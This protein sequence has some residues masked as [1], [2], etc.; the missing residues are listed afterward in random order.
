MP[1]L[2]AERVEVANAARQTLALEN[3][4]STIQARSF[5]RSLQTTWQV[6]VIQWTEPES[7]SQLA[8]SRRLVHA[9]GIYEDIEGTASPGAIECYRRAAE[10]LEWLSRANDPIPV[11][12]PIQL[13]AAA[14]FQLG[15][16]PAMA[17]GLLSQLTQD[18]RGSRLYASFLRADFEQTLRHATAFWRKHP[19]LTARGASQRILNGEDE[20]SFSWYLV[21]ELVRCVGLLADSLRRGNDERLDRAL[22][23]LESLDR[24]ATRTLPE[25]VSLFITL[26]HRVAVRFGKDSIYRVTNRLAA[27][28]DDFSAKLNLFAR[29]QFSI[30]RGILWVSQ[31]RGLDRLLEHSSFALCTPTGSGKTLVA[32]LALVKELLLPEEDG[33]SPLGLYLVPSRALAG[34]VEAKLTAELGQDFVITGLYGGADWGITDYWLNADRPTVLIATVEKA[35]ALMRYLGPL[36]LSRLRLLIIDEAHQVVS[37]GSANAKVEFAEHSSRSLRLE[38][39]VSR[40]LNQKPEIVRI[41]LTAVAGGAALPVARWVEGDRAAEPVGIRYRSTRQVIGVLETAPERRSR[42]LLEMMNDRPLYVRG[43]D[44]PVFLRIQTPVMPQL[45][46]AMRNSIYRFNELS[47]LWTALHLQEGGRRILISVM[48]E[49]EQTM[50]WYAEA[51]ALEDWAEVGT[52][53]PPEEATERARFDETRA[54]CID[55]CGE[56][57]YEL[58]LLDRGI[59]TNHG[60]MPQ[61]LRRLMTDLI[62]RKICPVTVATAT[63]TE[64]VNLPFDLIFVTS[65]KRRFY[66]QSLRQIVDAP[67]STAEFRNLAGRAGRPGAGTGIEGMTLVALPQSPSSTAAT[68]RRTQLRQ[69]RGLREDYESLLDRLAADAR[70]LDAAVSPLALLLRSIAE[71]ARRLLG[72]GEEA[73]LDWIETVLPEDVSGNVGLAHVSGQARLADSIDELDGFLLAALEELARTEDEDI[74]GADAEAFLA[75]LWTST[76]ANSAAVQEAWLERAFIARG[77]GIVEIVYPD[78]EERRRLYQYG[79]SPQVGRRFEAVAPTIRAELENADGY[80]EADLPARLAVFGT[81]GDLLAGA[82]GFGFR[83]R[84]T[85]TDQQL[86]RNWRDVLAWWMQVPGAVP[87]EPEKLRAWQRFVADNL[88]FRLGVAIGAVVAQ[89]WSNG[90]DDPLAVPSLA[91]WKETTGLPWFGF[92]A[93]ELLRWGTLEPFVAFSLAQGIARTREEAAGQKLLFDAWLRDRYLID[94]SPEDFID[95]QEFLEWQRSREE[96]R[97]E[98]APPDPTVVELTGTDGGKRRYPVIPVVREG[99]VDWIDA[100]GNRLALSGERPNWIGRRPFRNDYELRVRGRRASVHPVFRAG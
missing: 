36:L 55:Y 94:P 91:E 33:V 52:F 19:N 73:F 67:L 12:V 99:A 85:V 4:L 15:G 81:I 54:A 50:R 6:P 100:S 48:Q 51:F 28:N 34:E 45:P 66:D 8:D 17:A 42:L 40:V 69:L 53:D 84:D 63:L 98:H 5:V 86:L 9:A 43:R 11:A 21:V 1:P 29:R 78:Q 58:A 57:S 7:A 74:D 59:A 96:Q 75:R 93:K 20:D 37:D 70:A 27:Q 68:T 18:D 22:A 79:F 88:E 56:N 44:E 76:F 39:L 46:A 92:W 77:R 97:E 10:L 30:G 31:R 3:V 23:K 2:D 71:R 35:D 82:G 64:G 38:S 65:L 62:D 41:A 25:D 60:Q 83:A 90:A 80:G 87:P 24:L 61:R 95:P 89:A 72:L 47:V 26:L 16:L 49:P 32:N 14:A 13:Q